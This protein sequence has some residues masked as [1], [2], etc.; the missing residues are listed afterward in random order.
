MQNNNNIRPFDNGEGFYLYNNVT[1]PNALLTGSVV[2]NEA[3]TNAQTLQDLLGEVG[4]VPV[5]TRE[6]PTPMDGTFP[7]TMPQQAQGQGQGIQNP[8]EYALNFITPS[9]Q[10]AEPIIDPNTGAAITPQEDNTSE[11]VQTTTTQPPVQTTGSQ[12]QQDNNNTLLHQIG[13]ATGFANATPQDLEGVAYRPDMKDAPL[14]DK[15]V[16]RTFKGIGTYLNDLASMGGTLIAGASNLLTPGAD[17]AKA[18]DVGYLKR[19]DA[20]KN[21]VSQGISD[22]DALG[23]AQDEY[24]RNTGTYRNLEMLYGF[25]MSTALGVQKARDILKKWAVKGHINFEDL[26]QEDIPE[27]KTGEFTPRTW[28]ANRGIWTQNWFGHGSIPST[29]LNDALRAIG[30]D[31]DTVARAQV[32]PNN[33]PWKDVTLAMQDAS[34]AF[35]DIILTIMGGLGLLKGTLQT[36][37]TAEKARLLSLGLKANGK[38]A[39]AFEELE[40]TK[41]L[42][43]AANKASKGNKYKLEDLVRS[44]E[45]GSPL[46]K[47]LN[48]AMD[49]FRKFSEMYD[50][51]IPAAQKVPRDLIAKAQYLVRKTNINFQDALKLVKNMEETVKS[52]GINFGKKL[53]KIMPEMPEGLYSN[54]NIEFRRGVFKDYVQPAATKE[55]LIDFRTHFYSMPDKVQEFMIAKVKSIKKYKDLTPTEI[56][57]KLN[58]LNPEKALKLLGKTTGEQVD[59]LKKLGVEYIDNYAE[60]YRGLTSTSLAGYDKLHKTLDIPI[61]STVKDIKHELTHKVNDII[62]SLYGKHS[63]ANTEIGRRLSAKEKGILEEFAGTSKKLGDKAEEDLAEK[64]AKMGKNTKY[65]NAT[66]KAVSELINETAESIKKATEG[67]S[68]DLISAYNKAVDKFNNGEIFAVPHA[69]DEPLKVFGKKVKSTKGKGY[70]SERVYG[71]TPIEDVAKALEKGRWFRNLDEAAGVKELNNLFQ[72]LT[73]EKIQKLKM[74]GAITDDVKD[75]VFISK[76]TLNN[77]KD[78]IRTLKEGGASLDGIS[79]EKIADYIPLDKKFAEAFVSQYQ[80]GEAPFTGLAKELYDAERWSLLS[81]GSYLLGNTTGVLTQLLQDA[82]ISTIKDIAKAIGNK[83]K[84]SRE[85]GTFR[86]D[87]LHVPESIPGKVLAGMNAL[88]GG[89]VIANIDRIIQNIGSEAAILNRMR[90]LG[91]KPGQEIE[92]IRNMDL[93]EKGDLASQVRAISVLP[94]GR[95]LPKK[96]H[97]VIKTVAPFADFTFDAAPRAAAWLFKEHPLVQGIGVGLLLNDISSNYN[98][99]QMLNLNVKQTPGKSLV[100]EPKTGR[101][102][103]YSADITPLGSTV[104]L[105]S[106]AVNAVKD[107]ANGKAGD[108]S[109]QIL[110][111]SQIY[112]A[113]QGKDRYGR[114][115]QIRDGI[116]LSGHR[117]K[118]ENGKVVQQDTP[119]V[120]EIVAGLSQFTGLPNIVNKTVGPALT[121]TINALK[122]SDYRFYQPYGDAIFGSVGNRGEMPAQ[123]GLLYGGNPA[124]AP[125]TAQ[126]FLLSLFSGYRSEH[127]EPRAQNNNITPKTLRS[128][129]RQGLRQQQKINRNINMER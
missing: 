10:A 92:A 7:S 69:S 95:L 113:F 51:L 5:V 82:P 9:A 24:I 74:A 23:I 118:M 122:G 90:K 116:N 35:I 73:P 123:A 65:S 80:Y 30:S 111:L 27:I 18:A 64:Y 120:S 125:K 49:S 38:A 58:N 56:G 40:N 127:Y 84:L 72:N 36:A 77:S 102:M 33:S 13:L 79:P 55:N 129:I 91:V 112:N 8:L 126:D 78:V 115:N 26:K 22:E 70:T 47:E 121:E 52:A 31:P 88:S 28:L 81:S 19:T 53:A 124:R 43:N 103:D 3:P 67:F 39:Q 96:L 110:G 12:P 50:D 42:I 41:A 100:F 46:P 17:L 86:T 93:L 99:Q 20:Y 54:L 75:A 1:G 34:G 105:A 117:Y 108:S 76:E 107:F 61:G 71:N 98:M 6:V 16:T 104:R 48:S 2:W 94:G 37:S 87:V 89:G 119:S 11:Q 29:I 97:D 21:A 4:N 32:M 25:G 66:E 85:L 57:K 63:S 62:S 14:T 106:E 59:R 45:T 83:G 114:K 44:A 109:P 101:I 60:G 128:L 68:D 15:G